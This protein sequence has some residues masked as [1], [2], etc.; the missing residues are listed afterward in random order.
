MRL[1]PL[2]RAQIRLVRSS[3]R[4]QIRLVQFLHLGDLVRLAPLIRED[5]VSE[6]M[7]EYGFWR[8][9]PVRTHVL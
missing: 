1:A 6:K 4:A 2:M 9:K 8:R 3:L 5:S 7:L